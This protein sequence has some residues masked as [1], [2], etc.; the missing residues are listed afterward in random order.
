MICKRLHG[1][2][3]WSNQFSSLT[4]QDWQSNKSKNRSS[5]TRKAEHRTGHHACSHPEH[6]LPPLTPKS[7]SPETQVTEDTCSH[8]NS[9][10]PQCWARKEGCTR[11]VYLEHSEPSPRWLTLRA[12]NV[13]SHLVNWAKCHCPVA[14]E[15]KPQTQPCVWGCWAS[16]VL[17]KLNTA[18]RA[19]LGFGLCTQPSW[20]GPELPADLSTS[21][22][23]YRH[24]V[25]EE[26]SC[27]SH[28]G[29]AEFIGQIWLS[30]TGVCLKA[31]LEGWWLAPPHPHT[32]SLV[33]TSPCFIS[34]WI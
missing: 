23:L 7:H 12:L 20:P 21:I 28:G 2:C 19:K 4:S 31:G 32:L 6:L 26:W 33:I 24:M 22:P 14:P 8:M 13:P 34:L 29:G 18:L 27:H 10:Q 17:G 5:N 30:E 3:L 16:P 25:Q 15:T 9:T 1:P 11:T